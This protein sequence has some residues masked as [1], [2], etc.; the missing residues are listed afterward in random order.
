MAANWSSAAIGE[1]LAD[2]FGLDAG[3]VSALG[4]ESDQNSAV[5]LTN[6][7]R[8]VVKVSPPDADPDQ[9]RWQHEL[10]RLAGAPGALG[11]ATVPTMLPARGGDTVVSIDREGESRAVTV[12]S[13]LDGRTLSELGSHSAVLLTELG[14][15]AARLVRALE[16]APRRPGAT[17]HHWDLLRAPEAIAEGIESVEDRSS[18]AEVRRILSW[19][20]RSMSTHGASLPV[21][22]VHHDLNDFNVLARRGPDGRHHVHAVL[23]FA[24]ALH[25]ARISEL[26]IAVAYAMLRKPNPLS[27][28]AAVIRGYADELDLTDAELS[29]LYPLAAT[30][31]CV[32]A[33]T[34]TKRCAEAG[35]AY[36]H[37]RM[38]NTW[39]TIALLAAT[40]PE[41][42]EIIFREAAGAV[43]DP[44]AP[45]AVP[46]ARRAVPHLDF[47][48]FEPAHEIASGG[49]PG[50][51]R[52]GRP[53]PGR[54]LAGRRSRARP[55][56]SDSA[57]S[58][59]QPS[60]SE[61]SLPSRPWSRSAAAGRRWTASR[62]VRSSSCGTNARARRRSGPAGQG[63]T[64]HSARAPRSGPAT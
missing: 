7:S 38:K 37:D 42:A 4:G 59:K 61:F 64:P 16:P 56:P 43:V 26:A 10:L 46:A 31:L 24:D 48:P 58:S 15:T 27:A 49:S 60:P 5:E 9:I 41:L 23:D 2:H 62:T 40:P 51:A 20:T 57:S 34:W 19:F 1:I 36:G 63:S 14:S 45:L 11:Q 8:V 3:P 47:V 17:S 52:L 54:P 28:A 13:W 39:P 12:Q 22:V 55:R 33:V 50:T 29:V 6:G 30:R 25:T 53:T 32:N 21:S 35:N 18:L 44:P